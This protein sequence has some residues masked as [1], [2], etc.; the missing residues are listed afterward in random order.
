MSTSLAETRLNVL[1]PCVA[2]TYQGEKHEKIYIEN[3]YCLQKGIQYKLY[4]E[5]KL[6]TKKNNEEKCITLPK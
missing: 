4:I 5:H 1:L 6:V 2:A 3:L